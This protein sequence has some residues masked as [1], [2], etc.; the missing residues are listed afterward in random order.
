[1]IK[2]LHLIIITLILSCAPQ[3]AM[4]DD[5]DYLMDS[6]DG[7]QY[8]LKEFIGKGKWTVVKVWSA[9]CPY[10]RHELPDVSDFHDAH[11]DKDAMVV[12][13]A[14]HLPDYG[15]PNAKLLKQ[16]ADSYLVE[17]PL[18]LVDDEIVRK[19]IDKPF[20]GVP[21]AF[22]YNPQGKYIKRLDGMVTLEDLEQA[23]Q[24]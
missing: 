15:K 18:L 1:M 3:T 9:Q 12:G 20:F 11:I 5:L 2:L 24:P 7:K 10:C 6:T 23:I 8:A 14:I 16:F 4:A 21:V 22:I 19:V 17:F 13:L